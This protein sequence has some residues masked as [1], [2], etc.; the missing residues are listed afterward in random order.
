MQPGD[1]ADAIPLPG[2]R[3]TAA[4]SREAPATGGAQTDVDEHVA[5]ELVRAGMRHGLPANWSNGLWISWMRTGP[6]FSFESKARELLKGR[7]PHRELPGT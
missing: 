3:V 2:G 7:L 6:C 5:A 1:P 4:R